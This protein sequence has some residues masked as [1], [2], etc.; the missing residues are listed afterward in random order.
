MSQRTDA[1]ASPSEDAL[2]AVLTVVQA[3]ADEKLEIARMWTLNSWGPAWEKLRDE[4]EHHDATRTRCVR[5]LHRLVRTVDVT[6]RP[7]C[8]DDLR[9]ITPLIEQIFAWQ[10]PLPEP[11][12]GSFPWRD[13]EDGT[14]EYILPQSHALRTATERL[15]DLSHTF[16]VLMR[17]FTEEWLLWMTPTGEESPGEGESRSVPPAAQGARTA[18]GQEQQERRGGDRAW[19]Q[20]LNV[21]TNGLAEERAERAARLLRDETLTANDKLTRIDELLPFPPTASA[22]QLGELLGVTKQAVLKTVWWELNRKGERENEV[23]RR[24]TVHQQ[25]GECYEQSG[26]EGDEAR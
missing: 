22:E 4:R 11:L 8:L 13:R 19:L 3:H 6:G 25:R 10:Q 1:P 17:R 12:G 5:L 24:R 9:E 20:L 15:R 2:N 7:R 18:S 16:G 14:R 26:D 23:G 21:F